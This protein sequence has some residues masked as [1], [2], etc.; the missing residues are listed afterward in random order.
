MKLRILLILIF[1]FPAITANAEVDD[2]KQVVSDPS[3][4]L[5]YPQQIVL[6]SQNEIVILDTIS[7]SSH[8]KQYS[9]DG[10]LKSG[11]I[12]S[13]AGS[14]TLKFDLGLT[15]VT[16]K[17]VMAIDS[18]DDS[19]YV[20]DNEDGWHVVKHFDKSGTLRNAVT[21]GPPSTDGGYGSIAIDNGVIFVE[22]ND[23]ILFQNLPLKDDFRH[24]VGKRG[25]PVENW[26]VNGKRLATILEN[27][28][29]VF[30]ENAIPTEAVDLNEL[31]PDYDAILIT[32][33]SLSHDGE[34]A[35][36][37]IADSKDSN[38][39]KPF[40]ALLDRFG[41]L[42]KKVEIASRVKSLDW[43]KLGSLYALCNDLNE[44]HVI[45]FDRELKLLS[46]FAIPLARPS[47]THPGKMAV[48]S[49]GA[50]WIDEQ[51]DL[52]ETQNPYSLDKLTSLYLKKFDNDSI[53]EITIMN[54]NTDRFAPLF[55]KE[56]KGS[57]ILSGIIAD[58]NGMPT[59]TPIFDCKTS[60]EGYEVSS[61]WEA[62]YIFL[63]SHDDDSRCMFLEPNEG[64]ILTGEFQK[65]EFKIDEKWIEGDEINNGLP[66]ISI[67]DNTKA[68]IQLQLFEANSAM[69]I[70]TL[71]LE[72]C[73]I[74]D[75]WM[76][77]EYIDLQL[78]YSC[79]DG[80]AVA[81][82]FPQ[83]LV[84]INSDFKIVAWIGLGDDAANNLVCGCYRD[85]KNYVLD[86]RYNLVYAFDDSAWE[87]IKGISIDDV[88]QAAHKLRSM[89]GAYYGSN[90]EYPEKLND[91][92]E[93]GITDK[94]GMEDAFQSF[95]GEAPVI[96]A[97][98]KFDYALILWG[99]DDDNTLFKAS[100]TG[101]DVL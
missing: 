83:G 46:D 26:D 82:W 17:N 30:N 73:K 31:M 97:R 38:E 63:S 87:R 90:D 57:I 2:F 50:I 55:L 37:G 96:Y 45:V 58:S 52:S 25:E 79:D 74:G 24:F 6:N 22:Y 98:D 81:Y 76:A 36:G 11:V 32:D 93:F 8:L 13:G 101:L 89:I 23:E 10:K 48:D 16:G 53:S 34:I 59:S 1:L 70:H 68:F 65:G 64:K 78:L 95:M 12:A 39:M 61:Y 41:K 92:I 20:L 85:G 15:I 5:I 88:R 9:R 72:S 66:S 51:T 28:I 94:K 35:L 18:T 99:K 54:L 44:S 67:L 69:P 3:D 14:N 80:T 27:Q 60:N 47:L 77:S 100:S 42:K 62:K 43:S 4:K 40:L 86:A 84:R 56:I 21:I 7:N 33:L 71:D 19:F 29:T 75:S 91:I 49:N